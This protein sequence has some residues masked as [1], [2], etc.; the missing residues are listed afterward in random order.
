VIRHADIADPDARQRALVARLARRPLPCPGG[1]GGEVANAGCEIVETHISRVLLSGACAYKFKRPVSLGFLDFSTLER[2]R[3]FAREELRLNRRLAA[4]LYLD[5]LAV[6]GTAAEPR[7]ESVPRSNGRARVLDYVVRMRRFAESDLLTRR[8]ATPDILDDLAGRL[9]AFH[10]AAPSAPGGSDYGTPDA[11]LRP[12]LDNFRMI[13]EAAAPD[14]GLE[15]ALRRLEAWTRQT[16]D[17]LLPILA[18]RGRLGR[19]RECH[20]DLHLGNIA[21]VDGVPLAFDCI[22]FSPGLR[23]IDIISEIAF[24]LMDLHRVGQPRLAR[25]LLNRYLALS[26]DYDGLALLGFYLVYRAL[27]RAKV[28]ALS[29]AEHHQEAMC[30]ADAM[31]LYLREALH[32]TRPSKPR[33]VILCGLSGSGKS[34]LGAALAERLPLIQLRSDVERK[35]LFGLAPWARSGADSGAD[36]YTPEATARTY[37]RLLC[38]ARGVVEAGHGVLVDAT[39]QSRRQRDAFR[40]LAAELGC[41]F[42]ILALDAPGDVLRRRVG[43]RARQGDDA[44]EAG[45][46]VLERQFARRERLSAVERSQAMFID[47]R[48]VPG[49]EAVERLLGG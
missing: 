44:S 22:D 27:V 10:A 38:L 9:A 11:V 25:R 14:P 30:A 2:R 49:I 3:H 7:L 1:G 21:V 45:V 47:S 41:P 48:G 40:G 32:W 39:F 4:P 36:I 26:G 34:V 42:H 17:D 6:T 12:M 43:E 29:G 46:A 13:R 23:W 33:L 8:L 15:A 16:F 28:S 31:R 37:A 24:L 5:V 20:G 35:R 19:I 18:E